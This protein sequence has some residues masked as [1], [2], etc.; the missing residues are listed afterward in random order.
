MGG[1]KA[2]VPAAIVFISLLVI[3]AAFSGCAE[4]TPVQ[5][6]NVTGHI[7]NLTVH[8]LDVG[9]GDS[10]LVQFASKNILIDGGESDMGD[11]VASYLRDHGVSS[12]DLVV[13]THPHSDHIGGLI[14]ILKAFPVT[15]VL[16]NGQAQSSQTYE[17]F[18][19]V[20]DQKNIAYKVA[21]RGQ[22]INLDPKLEIDVLNP[23]SAL[24]GDNLNENSIVLRITYGKVSFLLMGDAGKEAEKDLLS[25]GYDLNSDI[26]KVGHHGSRYSSSPEFL[27]V[28]SPTVSVIEVGNGNDYGHPAPE[29]LENLKIAGSVI[30]R[31]DLD[32]NIDVTTDGKSY[33]VATEKGNSGKAVTP[34]TQAPA[35]STEYSISI[36][37]TQFDAP[38][39]DRQNLNGE[40]I[41]I[42]NSG[43]NSVGMTGWMIF[44]DSGRQIYEFPSFTLNSG[45][46]V[47]VYTGKGSNSATELYMERGSPIWNNNGDTAILKDASGRVISQR[48]S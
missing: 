33:S 46:S 29:T 7:D 48:S 16:D 34:Y 47:K 39:D 38:G 28:V 6:D 24:F 32:S 36:S 3:I 14:T 35:V 18:L 20:I 45:A 41:Q 12:L 5:N 17:N 10:A 4:K 15:Q 21:K 9:Q 27:Q 19:T 26:L 23:P 37:A 30:Y 43:Q 1:I 2:R 42:T 13:A 40:W 44:D 11:R 31:T 22:K 8:F 25:S